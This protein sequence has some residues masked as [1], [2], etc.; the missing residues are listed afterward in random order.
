MSFIQII[1]Y[2]TD[3]ADEMQA[4]MDED[5]R[6]GEQSGEQPP[7]TRLAVAHDRD[8]PR[9]YMVIVEFPSYEEAMTNSK[10]PETGE[11]A[12]RMGEMVSSGPRYHNLEVMRSFP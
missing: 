12:A 10:R 2:E 7:F 8:N 9:R 6:A 11:F 3:R 5:S 4:M 1:E